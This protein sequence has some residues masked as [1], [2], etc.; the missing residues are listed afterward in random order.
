[1][2]E[3]L[4]WVEASEEAISKPTA[5]ISQNEQTCWIDAARYSDFGESYRM[6]P[7]VQILGEAE[8]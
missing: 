8:K 6:R 7:N 3:E 2:K 5:P 1:M 4:T